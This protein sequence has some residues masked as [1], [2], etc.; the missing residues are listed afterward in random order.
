MVID[1]TTESEPLEDAATR[2]ENSKIKGNELYKQGDYR[3]AIEYYTVAVDLQ[4]DNASYYG[5]RAASRIMLNQYQE[6]AGDAVR[7]VELDENFTKGFLRLARCQVALGEL[8]RALDSYK[9][10]LV[11][12]PSNKEVS[13]Q[14]T[15]LGRLQTSIN[16]AEARHSSGDHRTALFMLDRALEHMPAAY[17]LRFR[18]AEFLVA[19]RRYQDAKEVAEALLR[20]KVLNSDAL[21]LRGHCL[22]YMDQPEKAMEHWAQ[23]MR[24]EPDHVRAA[25]AY[26]STKRLLAA[27]EEGNGHV[28]ARRW[29]EA[30]VAYE[31]AL[32]ID[33]ADGQQQCGALAA[34]LHCN[35]AHALMQLRR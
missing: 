13:Q 22:Y 1:L 32:A 33:V 11:L 5:N 17:H 16:E 6:A 2:A 19:L 31:R 30:L 4:P 12:E 26:R 15:L 24:L 25:Q 9:R 7:S 28:A 10:A 29:T 20:L 8:Q 23:V 21:W 34:K 3:Q 18:R 35:R 27:K 14:M